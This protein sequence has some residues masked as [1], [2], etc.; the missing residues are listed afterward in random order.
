[1]KR[2]IIIFLGLFTMGAFAQIDVITNG[3]VGIGGVTTPLKKLVVDSDWISDVVS[4]QNTHGSIVF[5]HTNGLASMD[6]G[7]SQAFRIRQLSNIPFYMDANGNVGIGTI[8]PDTRLHVRES[9]I[10]S[11]GAS[12]LHGF[13]LKRDGFDTYELRHLDGGLSIYNFTDTRKEMTFLGD[14]RVGIGTTDPSEK[15][16]INDGSSTSLKLGTTDSNYALKLTANHDYGN[17]FS[18]EFG[19]TTPMQEKKITGVGGDDNG[20]KLYFSNYYGIG[21]AT[22]TQN[23]NTAGDINLYIT[24]SDD[25]HGSGNVGIGT[26]DTL[27]RKL[28]VDGDGTFNGN[29]EADDFLVYP[30]D[31]TSPW[32]DYVFEN[33][34]K[35][36][37]LKEVE[38]HIEEKGHLPNIPSAK[39]VEEKGSFSLGEMNKKLLEKVEELMLYTIQQEKRIKALEEELAK[40]KR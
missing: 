13:Q 29:V 26:T 33:D 3:N 5:G 16:E 30:T 10:T 21:F 18:L 15:L 11:D 12:T 4:F 38:K 20:S 9:F 36:L 23:A 7:A 19:V 32:P 14:G 24:G 8:D 6:L 17:R 39:E 37:P 40:T 28:A 34:Y 31:L 25:T 35:L 2:I 1:M 27:G 22:H